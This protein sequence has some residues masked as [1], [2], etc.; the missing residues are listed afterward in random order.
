MGTKDEIGT[1]GVAARDALQA[2][3]DGGA[4]QDSDVA[5]LSTAHLTFARALDDFIANPAQGDASS[6]YDPAQTACGN[7]TAAI[8]A[9]LP[10]NASALDK[11]FSTVDAARRALAAIT[12]PPTRGVLAGA[13]MIRRG[14]AT[15]DRAMPGAPGAP[16]SPA[17]AEPTEPYLTSLAK[18]FP[19]EALS[20]LLLVMSIDEKYVMVRAVMIAL[21]TLS[22]GV[23]RYFATRNPISG[24]PDW[25]AILVS[26]VSFL[27]YAAALLAFGP[28]FG[29]DNQTTRLI[30]T[31]AAVLWMAVLTNVVRQ[32]PAT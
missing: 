16:A 9:C 1:A 6:A 18:L 2:M 27:I 11:V 7:A 12:A 15:K 26:V 5:A 3:I 28:L 13:L 14:E 8:N 29:T 21:V 19:A 31:V 24:K 30:A 4:Y 23:L 17:G 25:L 32:A 20:A 10:G 22:S